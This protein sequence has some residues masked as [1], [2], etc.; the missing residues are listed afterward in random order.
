MQ[1]TVFIT[2][3]LGTEGIKYYQNS[4]YID[5]I[6]ESAKTLGH[7]PLLGWIFGTAN[8]TTSTLT[9]WQFQSYHIKTGYT[10]SS[11]ARDKISNNADTL[12]VLDYTKNRLLNE[13]IEG[14]TAVGCALI[15]EAIH[16]K[17]DMYTFAGL[18]LPAISTVS[19]DLAKKLAD[20][21]LDMGNLLTVSKQASY[22][23]LINS[24]TS[25]I[26]GL[27]YNE[28]KD[29]SWDLYKVRT[30]KILLYSNVIASASN[31]LIVAIGASV[32]LLT[33]NPALIKKSLRKLDVGGILVTIYRLITDC[34]FIKKVKQ[35]FISNEWHNIV[36]GD[37]Y[38]F[39]LEENNNE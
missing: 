11:Q 34:N 21:G 32:G 18:P 4:K 36:M 23:I 3:G 6:K 27:F 38:K 29:Q 7:D 8:I 31:V 16:L 30:H 28:T 24:L 25:M 39:L 22:A 37:E 1:A 10:A 14:K 33:E 19:P 15:K 9:T 12:K 2:H 5:L 13:G 26:H 35:E 17:S 20:Y